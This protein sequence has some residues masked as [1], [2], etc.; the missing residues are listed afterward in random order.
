MQQS[1][2]EKTLTTLLKMALHNKPCNEI[3][4]AGMTDN[5]WKDCY[6]L[7]AKHGVMA[8]AWDGMQSLH[9]NCIHQGLLS[10][11]GLWQ[12]GIMKKGMKDTVIR[13]MNCLHYMPGME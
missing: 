4:W 3:E 6:Q 13:L 9:L 10:C 12:S 7:A 1:R 5:D 11:H 8:V 2:I